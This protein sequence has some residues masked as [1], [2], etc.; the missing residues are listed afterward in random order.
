MTGSDHWRR[1]LPRYLRFAFSYT[2]TLSIVPLAIALIDGDWVRIRTGHWPTT[3]IAL[4]LIFAGF[5]FLLAFATDVGE[6]IR[7]TR[8]DHEPTIAWDPLLMWRNFIY[9]GA[10][11]FFAASFLAYHQGPWLSVFFLAFSTAS[12]IT[13][14]KCF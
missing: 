2:L 7:R 9:L 12:L 6:D 5:F 10:V 4:A 13:A 3:G 1:A 14:R 11:G 8:T